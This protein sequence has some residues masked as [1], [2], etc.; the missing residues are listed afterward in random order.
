[1]HK[2][3]SRGYS[4]ARGP[5]VT[6]PYLFFNI[7][8][9]CACFLHASVAPCVGHQYFFMSYSCRSFH[10]LLCSEFIDLPC[11]S[12]RGTCSSCW[13]AFHSLGAR[14]FV[15]YLHMLHER[16]RMV[17][18]LGA[19]R[20]VVHLLALYYAH[21]P[22]A[23]CTEMRGPLARVVLMRTVHLLGALGC[24]VHLHVLHECAWSTC[25]V[26]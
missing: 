5:C 15:V 22:L 10:Y 3:V 14:R 4:A 18:L 17:H 9:S 2:H 26:Y 6:T 1:M 25:W 8:T 20:S 11:V 21:G 19:L 23:W 24:V 12:D 13:C 7:N 16:M